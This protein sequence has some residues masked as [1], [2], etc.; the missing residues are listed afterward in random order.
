M[1][2][3]NV[4]N[5]FQTLGITMKIDDNGNIMFVDNVSQQKMQAFYT[6]NPTSFLSKNDIDYDININKVLSGGRVRISSN[7]YGLMFR[8]TNPTIDRKHTNDIVIE[9]MDYAKV[10]NGTVKEIYSMSFNEGRDP[11]VSITSTKN[12]NE[13]YCI[14][15]FSS[16]DLKFQK[17][18]KVG[19]FNGSYEED[20]DLSKSEMMDILNEVDLSYVIADYYSPLFPNMKNSIEQAK[21]NRIL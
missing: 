12:N 9:K 17:D 5:F 10:E 19:Y 16:G 18:V 20:S 15:M 6:T 7:N 2:L 11:F 21:Q 4:I 14:H 3:N 1:N 13:V 8:L